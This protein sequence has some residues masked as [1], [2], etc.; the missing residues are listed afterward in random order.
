MKSDLPKVL[1]KLNDKP[2]I[3]HV[4]DSLEKAGVHDITIVVGYRGELVIDE[5]GERAG[6]VW[7]REQLGTGHAVMQA[8]HVF[9]GKKCPVII[10]CGD[11]PLIRPETFINLVDEFDEPDVKAVVLTMD[12]E[13]PSVYGRIVK[14]DSGRFIKIVEYK[15]ASDDEKLITEVNTGTYIFDSEYL[16]EGLKRINTNNAQGEFYLPDALQYILSSG[17]R[18]KTLV[19]ENP[20][21]GSGINTK[22][23]LEALSTFM[24]SQGAK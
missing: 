5:V 7:Q 20:V 16:F 2:L 12:L 3:T 10:A 24:I 18:V 21:E 22:D 13:D 19:L 1:H 9:N 8:E 15:D 23:E 11:V 4:I 17:F 14:D 6:T